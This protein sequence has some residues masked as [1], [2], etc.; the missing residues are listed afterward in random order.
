M[1]EKYDP[2]DYQLY[3]TLIEAGFGGLCGLILGLILSPDSPVGVGLIVII[4]IQ[5]NII[6]TEYWRERVSN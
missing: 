3:Y 5:I 4:A 2:E 6:V 1:S